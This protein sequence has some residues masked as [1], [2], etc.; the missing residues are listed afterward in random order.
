MATDQTDAATSVLGHT[1]LT[2]VPLTKKSW[3]TSTHT[4]QKLIICLMC[5]CHTTNNSSKQF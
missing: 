1:H 5:L 4:E 3:L 2:A